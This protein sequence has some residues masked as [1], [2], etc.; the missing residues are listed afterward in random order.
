MAHITFQ[1]KFCPPLPEIDGSKDYRDKRELYE[2]MDQLITDL[3]LDTQ[4]A[5]LA[6][7]DHQKPSER[8]KDWMITAY[9]IQTVRMLSGVES[10]RQLASDLADSMLLQWFCRLEHFGVSKIKAPSK[11]T[12]DRIGKL[13]AVA[14]VEKLNNILLQACGSETE[15]RRLGLERSLEMA[16]AWF[17]ATCVKAGI[18]VEPA[19]VIFLHKKQRVGRICHHTNLHGGVHITRIKFSVVVPIACLFPI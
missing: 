1:Q 9:R 5:R 16:E 2:R 17:D 12:I 18:H 11:S 13:L 19:P 7:K 3:G 10:L 14:E 6:L 4:F 8:K 15:A